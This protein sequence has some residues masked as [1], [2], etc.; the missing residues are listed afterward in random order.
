MT[1]VRSSTASSLTS[2]L[3]M[4]TTT[5][6]TITLNVDSLS[7]LSRAANSKARYYAKSV[8]DNCEALDKLT[9]QAT[10]H[11]NAKALTDLK[12]EIATSLKDETYKALY[13]ESLAELA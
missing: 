7:Q 5:A 9:R 2:L 13:L 4:V 8:E 10:K 11:R 3:G 6:S 1:S 12:V